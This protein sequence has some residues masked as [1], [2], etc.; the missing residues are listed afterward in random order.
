MPV[1]LERLPQQR[2]DT[3]VKRLEMPEYFSKMREWSAQINEGTTLTEFTKIF[4]SPHDQSQWQVAAHRSIGYISSSLYL[5]CGFSFTLCDGPIEH[6][7]TNEM[8][9]GFNIAPEID[10]DINHMPFD[11]RRHRAQ[12]N[13]ED[14]IISQL[15]A[16]AYNQ[17]DF[18]RGWRWEQ[19]L[20]TLVV[21]FA[22]YANLGRVHIWPGELVKNDFAL[23]EEEIERFMT[24]YNGTANGLG[25]K[26]NQNG[27]YVL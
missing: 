7:G 14:V 26:R 19:A 23:T 8:A 9:I 10:V 21:D 24:R 22:H 13:R 12:I 2:E 15:Q 20:V 6:S 4:G 1:T 27:I 5:D 18:T 11:F 16:G 3:L 17:P 25:F